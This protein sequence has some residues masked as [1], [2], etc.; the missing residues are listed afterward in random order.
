[1][2]EDK[3]FH[4]SPEEFRRYGH[5]VV[6]WIADYQARVESFPVLSRVTARRNPRATAGDPPLKGEAFDKILSR[7]RPRDSAG[8]YALAISELFRLL[9]CQLVRAGNSRR[10]VSSG[11]GVQGMLWS[12]SPACTELGNPC[13]RLAGSHARPAGEVSFHRRG[14]GRDPGHGVER[15]ALRSARSARTG[16]AFASNQQGLRWAT[17]GVLLDANAFLR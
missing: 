6:D 7:D 14:R 2:P 1:M 9:P 4:M 12:T 10:P 11:L 16:D 15:V 13:A 8:S 3:S 17:G 5:A